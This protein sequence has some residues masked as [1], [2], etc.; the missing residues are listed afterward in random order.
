MSFILIEK[1]QTTQQHTLPMLPLLRKKLSSRM[2]FTVSGVYITVWKEWK[3][4]SGDD[5]L[6]SNIIPRD[7]VSIHDGERPDTWKAYQTFHL[8]PLTPRHT[9][10]LVTRAHRGVQGSLV[11]P[12]PLPWRWWD[13]RARSPGHP[14]RGRPTAWTHNHVQSEATTG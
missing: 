3:G 8:P 14:D 13:K 5:L 10:S 9:R 1:Q 7:D 2:T 12:S 4:D 11:S 6:V